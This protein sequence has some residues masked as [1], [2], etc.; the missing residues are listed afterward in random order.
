[1]MTLKFQMHLS[2]ILGV[3]ILAGCQQ[4]GKISVESIP[5]DKVSQTRTPTS[6][7][8]SDIPVDR[9]V[10]GGG[11]AGD[12]A[13]FLPYLDTTVST[14]R[15]A[16]FLDSSNIDTNSNA[17]SKI[18][19]Q[20]QSISIA[21]VRNLEV[22]GNSGNVSVSSAIRTDVISGNSGRVFLNSIDVSRIAGNSSDEIC[23][24]A[25]SVG[26]ISGNSAHITVVADTIE[27]L[28]GGSGDNRV[29][30][31]TIETIEGNSSVLHIYKA[32]IQSV[33]GQSG[34]ICLHNGAQI[35]NFD[36][37]NSAKVASDCL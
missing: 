28:S 8:T 26:S 35:V 17:D 24:N 32:K 5:I 31:N 25:K 18:T 36:S 9:P 27:T 16:K 3:L 37:S 34:L 4:S 33:H 13:T 23:I 21:R 29:T 15:C 19:G 14:E 20:S 2:A 10:T 6:T 11:S 1:M 30:A 22:T 7:N 12:S